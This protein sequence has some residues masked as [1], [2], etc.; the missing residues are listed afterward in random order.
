MPGFAQRQD[1]EPKPAVLM[2]AAAWLAAAWPGAAP[3]NR[4]S[5]RVALLKRVLPA[6]GVAL[7]LFGCLY[8]RRVEDDFADVI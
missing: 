1:G 2:N 4:H 6:V 3:D 7:F 5:R 8:F